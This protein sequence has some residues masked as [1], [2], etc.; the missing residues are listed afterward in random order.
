MIG[1]NFNFPYGRI[2]ARKLELAAT[3]WDRLT[4][5]HLL[6]IYLFTFYYVYSQ[7]FQDAFI[8]SFTYMASSSDL[9]CHIL[10]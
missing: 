4:F 9:I 3:I 5:L 8:Q 10:H 6:Y 7:V 1:F 2:A